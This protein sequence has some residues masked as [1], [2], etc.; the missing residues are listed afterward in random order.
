MAHMMFLNPALKIDKNRQDR[1]EIASPPPFHQRDYGMMGDLLIVTLQHKSTS[2][3]CIAG[4]EQN[5]AFDAQCYTPMT[6]MNKLT[7]PHSFFFKSGLI[8]RSCKLTH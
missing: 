8:S 5:P 7:D 3:T 1:G 2:N 6:T 4:S